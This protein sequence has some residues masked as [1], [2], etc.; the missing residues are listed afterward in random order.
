LFGDLLG[1]Q[2]AQVLWCK[3]GSVA[4]AQR[5]SNERESTEFVSVIQR[6]K[7][8]AG[9][10][11]RQIDHSLESVVKIDSDAKPT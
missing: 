2:L 9:Q 11:A 7:H 5:V 1:R 6:L 8:G 10:S 3:V 4:P